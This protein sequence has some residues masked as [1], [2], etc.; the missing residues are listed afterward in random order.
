MSGL[1]WPKIVQAISRS[2]SNSL[3]VDG[4]VVLAQRIVVERLAVHVHDEA[5]ADRRDGIAVGVLQHAGGVDRDVALRVA[6]HREDVGG[7]CGDGALDFDAFGHG[8]IVSGL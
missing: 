1:I 6:E 4:D 2:C 5:V 7:G 8:P 3:I